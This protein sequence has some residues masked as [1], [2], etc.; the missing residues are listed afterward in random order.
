MPEH[1]DRLVTDLSDLALDDLRIAGGKATHLGELERAGFPVPGGFVLTTSAYVIAARDTGI[2]PEDPEVAATRLRT[3]DVPRAV[4]DALIGAYHRLGS[5][6]VAVRSSA[7]AEDLPGV[8]FAGQ[9]DSFLEVD[10]DQAVLDA[11]RRCWASLWSERAVAYRRAN[12]IDEQGI[13]IAVVVQRMVT[14]SVAGVLFTADPLAG[15]RGHAVIEAVPGLG[16][17]L[18]SGEVNPDRY[19]VD[20]RNRRVIERIPQE[21]R[22]LLADS[23]L[24]ELAVMGERAEKHFGAPQDLEFAL[25]AERRIWLVQSRNITTLYPLPAG[26]P[27]ISADVRTYLSANVIQGYF[28]PL[29]PMGMQF[30]RMVAS[31]FAN[32]F[33]VRVEDPVVG[34]QVVVEA[35]MR[36][37]LDVTGAVR[38]RLGHKLLTGLA[39]VAESRSSQVLTRLMS[40]PRIMAGSGSA[41]PAAYRIGRS[42]FKLGAAPSIIRSLVAPSAARRRYV[43]ELDSV[44]AIRPPAHADAHECLDTVEHLLVNGPPFIIRRVVGM[45]PPALISMGLSARLLRGRASAEELQTVTRGAPHNPTTTMDLALWATSTT[46]RADAESRQV[47][48]DSSPEELAAG[49]AAG[50]LPTILQKEVTQFLDRY[51]FRCIGE[52]DIGVPRWSEDPTHIL[53]VIANYV[54]LEDSAF[55][56]DAKFEKSAGE[57]EAMIE[58]LLGRVDGPRRLAARFAL[59]R[60]REL[61]GLREAPK[62]NLVR[63]IATPTRE[64]L[65]PVG[66]QLA[67]AGRIPDPEAIFFLTIPDARRA[68]AGEDLNAVVNARREE[69]ARERTRRHIP[70]VLLSDGTDAESLLA[71]PTD[72]GTLVGSPASPG[73]LRGRARV[74][75]SPEGARIEPG[76][77]LVAPSTNPGWTPLFLTAGGLVM[78]MGG[79][80]SHGAVVAREYGIPAVVGVPGATDRIKSGSSIVVD[81]SAGTVQLDV[82]S[83]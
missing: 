73:T 19:T 37:F 64:L 61:I 49:Y 83:S 4:S 54:R 59:G 35:G 65:K 23:E 5:G 66:E 38:S 63:L 48:L 12:D 69:F 80:M 36:F 78:E 8:S 70:R 29:T 45:I 33:G 39:S 68:L 32:A 2:S 15:T 28:D 43:A 56:P 46:V 79:A 41:R 16:D 77:I 50:T 67:E 22:Q 76:E 20:T 51:G 25:D 24:L 44:V 42:V 75:L 10:G 26:A 1:S 71:A 18:L 9:Q 6:P 21:A 17:A 27:D 31:G 60:V 11:V 82:D 62:Y 13:A 52:I 40:D 14:A 55:N 57:A 53:G 30:F 47:L 58:E 81:G 34:P 7:T 72:S 74:I 3:S